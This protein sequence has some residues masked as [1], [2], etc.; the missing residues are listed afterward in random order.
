MSNTKQTGKKRSREMANSIMRGVAELEAMLR[1]G[2]RP[3]DR[4]LVRVVEFPEPGKYPPQAVKKLRG[5]LHVSQAGFASLV[6]VSRIL[7]ASWERGA[8]A[9]SPLARRLLD[10]IN[11]DPVGWLNNLGRSRRAG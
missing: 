9:P 5:K 7:V 4:F 6:G 10:T 2:A 3:E 1:D 11:A 8:R